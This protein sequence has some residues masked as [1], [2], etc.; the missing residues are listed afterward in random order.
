MRE[1]VSAPITS[2]RLNAPVSQQTIRGREREHEAGAH[3]L[4]IEGRATGD[5]EPGLHRHRGRRK[6]VVGRRGRRAR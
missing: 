3:R 4:Q 2:A 1:K 6:G 5:A